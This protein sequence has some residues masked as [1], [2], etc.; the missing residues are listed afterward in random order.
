MLNSEKKKQIT[1][2]LIVFYKLKQNLALNF[3]G[4]FFKLNLLLCGFAFV[5]SL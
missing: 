2:V 1:G 5:F 4:E 3:G